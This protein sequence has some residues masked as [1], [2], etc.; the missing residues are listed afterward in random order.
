M[1]EEVPATEEE[2]VTMVSAGLAATSPHMI[3][4][5]VGAL[6]RLVWEFHCELSLSLLFSERFLIAFGF[7]AKLEQ[8]Y[9]AELVETLVVFLTSPNREIVKSA[10]GFIKVSIVSLPASVITPSLPQLVPALINW[11]HEHSN[12]FKVNIRHLFERM[13]RKYGYNEI[14]RYVPEDDKKLVSSIRKRQ[15][16]SKKKRL[17]K[18]E[19]EEGE[20]EDEEVSLTTRFHDPFLAETEPRLLCRPHLN[21]KLPLVPLT[22]K[23]FTVQIRRDPL[24]KMLLLKIQLSPLLQVSRTGSRW[25]GR[26]GRNKRELIFRKMKMRFSIF[27]M[28]E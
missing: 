9:L 2:F 5:T 1:E 21:L 16:R 17:E 24:M 10:I 27:W 7:I 12:H 19:T 13:I 20:N 25:R 18:M 22:M 23:S 3:A 14:E 26:I 4:A 11:S 6:G 15:A 8:S 28:T